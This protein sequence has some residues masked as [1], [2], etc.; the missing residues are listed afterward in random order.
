MRKD[1]KVLTKD[2]Y[3]V[4]R[5]ISG[6]GL[7]AQQNIKKDDYI[8]EY[9]GNI[10]TN[11][12]VED[13][14]TMYLFEVNNKFTIDGSPRWN[15]ARYINHSC[16]KG[17][18]ESKIVNSRVYIKAIKD[19]ALGEEITYDYGNEFFKKFIKP[20]GCRCETCIKKLQKEKIQK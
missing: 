5:G 4:K 1:P 16:K 3:K 2:F 14:T 20:F 8:I 9:I 11:K 18:A 13:N 17:N 6:F 19:I 12:E 10:K 7:F 15:T